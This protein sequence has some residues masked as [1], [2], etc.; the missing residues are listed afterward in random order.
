MFAEERG[1]SVKRKIPSIRSKE[2]TYRLCRALKDCLCVNQSVTSIELQGIPL[3]ERDVSA[4]A[5][6]CCSALI[7][8]DEFEFLQ[9]VMQLS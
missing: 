5:K 1:Y 7:N 3:R 2:I 6:V 9:A 4:L 8:A